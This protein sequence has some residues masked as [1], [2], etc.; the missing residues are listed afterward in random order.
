[1][2]SQVKMSKVNLIISYYHLLQDKAEETNSVMGSISRT[3]S[4]VILTY[5]WGLIRCLGSSDISFDFEVFQA[6]TQV[7][8]DIEPC[9]RF[10]STFTWRQFKLAWSTVNLM[11]IHLGVSSF[12]PARKTLP[13]PDKASELLSFPTASWSSVPLVGHSVIPMDKRPRAAVSVRLYVLQTMIIS[14]WLK[15]ADNV[16][17]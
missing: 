7:S 6:P 9:V 10:P 8:P 13:K 17:A 4:E 15:R 3:A 14:F 11:P 16:K 5:P 12:M 1:M 2:S